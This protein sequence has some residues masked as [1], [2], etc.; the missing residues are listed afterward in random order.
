MTAAPAI[1]L[2]LMLF[3]AVAL[4]LYLFSMLAR[5]A[6]DRLGDR[7]LL[8]ASVTQ[9]GWGAALLTLLIGAAAVNTGTNLLYL[10]LSTILALFFV[11][12]LLG[13]G[14]LSRMAVALHP[15]ASV[16][17]RELTEIRAEITNRSRLLGSFGVS[18][19]QRVTDAP[20]RAGRDENPLLAGAFVDSL[21]PRE[22]RELAIPIR[23]PSRGEAELRPLML[24]S[25]FPFGMVERRARRGGGQRVLVYPQ[26][27]EIGEALRSASADSGSTETGG[28]G[29]GLGLYSIRNYAAGDPAKSIHWKL[30][31]KGL[32]LMVREHEREENPRYRICIQPSLPPRP[33]AEDLARFERALSVGATLVRRLAEGGFEV[34]LWSPSGSVRFGRGAGH[35]HSILR[36]L[37]LASWRD[38]T[39]AAE[40]PALRDGV[41]LHVTGRERAKDEPPWSAPAGI[42]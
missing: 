41:D 10:M 5:M 31:A 12:F 6:R 40:P 22:R 27:I 26:R 7:Y 17:A 33:D 11:S 8:P 24:I 1:T 2:F 23:F 15:P 38:C 19:L 42:L 39:A 37:A 9:T 20:G 3:T 13:R 36:L 30:S 32:G 29:H 21:A 34:G 16:H 25:V 28:K 18:M 14:N 35:M 4:T